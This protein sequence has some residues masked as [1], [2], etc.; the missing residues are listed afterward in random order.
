MHMHRQGRYAATTQSVCTSCAPLSF[1]NLTGQTSC[2]VCPARMESD[3]TDALCRYM[4][5][6]CHI[7]HIGSSVYKGA[8]IALSIIIIPV[9]AQLL[10]I[11]Y[12][13]LAVLTIMTADDGELFRCSPGYYGQIHGPCM[14]K[15]SSNRFLEV[16]VNADLLH[17]TGMVNISILNTSSAVPSVCGDGGVG[18]VP[19]SVFYTLDGSTPNGSST[20]LCHD[21]GWKDD[22][23]FRTWK[24]RMSILIPGAVHLRVLGK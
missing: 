10:F 17:D 2:N 22:E 24:S 3:A 8:W 16:H 14:C 6:A 18:C 4:A 21:D 5:A 11:A 15:A 19:F 20:I 13:I 9:G 1:Q 12:T 23:C 7:K